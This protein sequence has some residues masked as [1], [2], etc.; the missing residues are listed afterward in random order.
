MWWV[1]LVPYQIISKEHNLMFLKLHPFWKSEISERNLPRKLGN[2]DQKILWPLGGFRRRWLLLSIP[3][4]RGGCQMDVLIHVGDYKG[5]MV[6]HY[7]TFFV[8]LRHTMIHHVNHVSSCYMM[9]QK[10][11]TYIIS[12]IILRRAVSVHWFPTSWNYFWKAFHQGF[13]WVPHTCADILILTV[14]LIQFTMFMVSKNQS[15]PWRFSR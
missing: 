10:N 14:P 1:F 2:S 5:F 15:P 7:V 8:S 11:I 4:G 3:S 13:W 6:Y 12:M 9:S